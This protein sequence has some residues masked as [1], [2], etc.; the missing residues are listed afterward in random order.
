MPVFAE[1]LLVSEHLRRQPVRR[2]VVKGRLRT[3]ALAKAMSRLIAHIML[4]RA[5][6]PPAPLALGCDA[7]ARRFWV[8]A[9]ASPSL[10]HTSGRFRRMVLMHM[11]YGFTIH[12]L[13]GAARVQAM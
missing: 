4:L 12:G 8:V 3:T 7:S 6:L 9:A 5:R 10:A 13:D 2:N 1:D 11:T